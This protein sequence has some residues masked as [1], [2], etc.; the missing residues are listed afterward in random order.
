LSGTERE[1]AIN[2]QH[3]TMAR[4]NE[5]RPRQP[6]PWSTPGMWTI[7]TDSGSAT[8]GYLPAWA[9]DDPSEVDVPLHLLLVRLADIS[10]RNF[11]EGQM[12][13]VVAPDA[14]GVAEEEA[15]FEGSIDCN[16]YAPDPRERVPVVNIQVCLDYW[17]LGLDPEGLAGIAAKLRDQAELLETRIRPALIAAREDWSAHHPSPDPGTAKRTGHVHQPPSSGTGT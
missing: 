8:S 14:H 3:D 15:V 1:N 2:M 13:P 16:P 6:A 11:F 10:H 12:M 5:G 4:V 9:E 7:A 17:I